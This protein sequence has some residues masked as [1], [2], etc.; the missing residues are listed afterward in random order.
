MKKIIEVDLA[1][2]LCHKSKFKSILNSFLKII[3][4]FY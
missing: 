4:E 3:D 2:L 1:I